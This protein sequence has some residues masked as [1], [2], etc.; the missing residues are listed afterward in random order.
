M[1]TVNLSQRTAEKLYQTIVQEAKPGDK[2]P[3]E[4]ELAQQLGVSRATLREAIRILSAQGVLEVQRGKGT[5]IRSDME[6][7]GD[8]LGPLERLKTRLA[9]LFEI[10]LF[11]EPDCAALAC[12]RATE[13]EMQAIISQGQ[14]V[15]ELVQNGGNWPDADEIFHKRIAKASHNAFV[16]RL[17]PIINSAIHDT[18]M[19]ANN[20][21]VLGELVVSDNRMLIEFFRR[22]DS[23]GARSAMDIHMRH[24]MSSL[25]LP[26]KRS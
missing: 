1:N 20:A 25:G 24:V 3:N 15:N 13:A 4:L 12:E 22:R 7:A 6:N 19:I 2:L 10:R 16:I 5:F 21:A 18:M 23:D 17:L 9:D 11:F 14:H 8:T 26:T